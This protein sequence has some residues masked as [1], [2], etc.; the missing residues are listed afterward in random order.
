ML[1][2]I[3]HEDQCTFVQG[4][5]TFDALRS[6]DDVMEYAKLHNKFGLLTTFD[7]KKANELKT[8]SSVSSISI[9]HGVNTVSVAT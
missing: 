4:G 1:R 2:D 5:T 6:I 8:W 3:I 9:V 7:F